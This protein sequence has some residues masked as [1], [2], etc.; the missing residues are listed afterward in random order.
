MHLSRATTSRPTRDGPPAW[1]VLGMIVV[2]GPLCYGAGL[3]VAAALDGQPW[4]DVACFDPAEGYGS[5]VRMAAGMLMGGGAAVSLLL[6]PWLLGV[7]AFRR[8]PGFRAMS[9][10][11]SLA[12]SC[13]VLVLLCVALRYFGAVT[14]AGLFGAWIAWTAALAVAAGRH[15]AVLA[16]LHDLVR[17][18]GPGLSVGLATIAVAMVVFHREQF[19]QS[20]NGDGTEYDL[21]ARSVREHFLPRFEQEPDGA[22]GIYAVNPAVVN[23]YWTMSFQALLGR[24]ELAARLPCWL[25]WFGIFAA[26][27][28]MVRSDALGRT[29]WSALA[30]ALLV[31]L[32]IVWYTFYCGYDP[33]MSDLACPGVPDAL[34]T[35][36]VLLALDS[37]RVG[38]AAGWVAAMLL[39]SMIF[40]AGPVMFALMAM[41]GVAWQPL[42]RRRMVGASLAGAAVLVALLLLYLTLGWIDGSLGHWMAVIRMEWLDKYFA[43]RPLWRE[44]A[45]FLGYFLLGCGGVPVLGLLVGLRRQAPTQQ[46][47]W[48]RTAAT[49]VVLYLLIILGCGQKNLHYLGALL[50][51]PLLLWLEPGT[52]PT[53]GLSPFPRRRPSQVPRGRLRTAALQE[54]RPRWTELAAIASLAVCLVLSWPAARP[55]FMLNRELGA[56]TTFQTDDFREACLWARICGALYE[57]GHLGW[58]IGQHTWAAYAECTARPAAPRPLL[59]TAGA[60]PS[61]QYTL[62]FQSPEGVKLFCR[63][64]QWLRWAAEQ[65]PAAGPQRFPWTLQPIAIAPQPRPATPL[66]AGTAKDNQ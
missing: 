18:W 36:L 54:T 8:R 24:G 43:A 37:L 12:I 42:A 10:L 53:E 31:L 52:G 27:F 26:S 30:L 65:Q 58:Q 64:P 35:L 41:A 14:R 61:T 55:V 3:A 33:Y 11:W 32:M 45:W 16:D 34:F 62:V 49:V 60:R 59:V 17:R 39:A 28:R 57:Q 66:P 22:W 25:W 6:A 51:I 13:C 48:Q 20:F 56:I 7:L 40:Y 46:R 5:V 63:D 21:L 15:A 29:L 4:Q 1:L 2:A 47:A 44:G 19:L 9:H 50:P 23:S 38:D